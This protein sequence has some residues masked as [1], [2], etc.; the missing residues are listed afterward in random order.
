[1]FSNLLFSSITWTALSAIATAIMA[2]ATLFTLRQNQKQLEEMK[3]Q[4]EES[5]KP[6]VEPSVVIPNYTLKEASF[7]IQLKNIGESVAEIQSI[8]IEDSFIKSFNMK[9]IEDQA[10][11]IS[12]QKYHIAPHESICLT[13][14]GVTISGNDYNIS[15]KRLSSEEFMRIKNVLHDFKVRI[16]CDYGV[17]KSDI[18]FTN[19]DM[20]YYTRTIQDELSDIAFNLSRIESVIQSIG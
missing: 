16:I 5:R 17:G 19:Y 2:F 11:L 13:I 9:V 3:R 6:V 20:H 14:C 18:V 8:T 12:S 1:M 4:W 15:G 10:Q 7:G